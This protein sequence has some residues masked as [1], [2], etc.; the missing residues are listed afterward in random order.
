VSPMT[1]GLAVQATLR[2]GA[3]PISP[4]R[5]LGVVA[6]Y[7]ASATAAAVLALRFRDA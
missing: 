2:L 4:W 7:A 6:L 5:G 1:A 3:L